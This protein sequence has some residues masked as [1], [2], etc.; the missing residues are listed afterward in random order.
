MPEKYLTKDGLE[1]LKKELERLKKEERPK[2]AQ[3][4]E[5]AI[6]LVIY[7]KMLPT[8]RQRMSALLEGKI[9]SLESTINTQ[10][11]L[12]KQLIMAGLILVQK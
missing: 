5:E 6:S 11:L 12:K 2:V 3:Q 10:L 8:M 7:Q 1:K 4:L 9:V